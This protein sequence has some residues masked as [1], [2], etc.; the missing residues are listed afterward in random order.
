MAEVKHTSQFCVDI[1]VQTFITT[2][3]SINQ[4]C[5]WWCEFCFSLS[6]HTRGREIQNIYC[7]ICKLFGNKL[8]KWTSQCPNEMT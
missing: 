1:F 7:I 2:K 4:V 8:F 5:M 3:T 6:L